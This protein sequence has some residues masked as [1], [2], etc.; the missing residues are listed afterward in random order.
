MNSKIL[1]LVIFISSFANALTA[2]VD[3]I[4]IDGENKSFTFSDTSNKNEIKTKLP[5]QAICD[6]SFF[7][8]KNIVFLNCSTFYSASKTLKSEGGIFKS[9]VM[10]DCESNK[11][12]LLRI[13][14]S[15]LKK[16]DPKRVVLTIACFK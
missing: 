15:G 16:Y 3:I 8:D 2:K 9:S 13:E 1:I 12:E 5:G 14:T 7:A 4:D 11:P 10:A 6:V